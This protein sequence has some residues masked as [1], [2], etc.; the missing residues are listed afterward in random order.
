M[1][2]RTAD[3]VVSAGNDI[4]SAEALVEKLKEKTTVYMELVTQR[5]IQVFDKVPDLKIVDGT[6]KIHQV[7]IS[8]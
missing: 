6:M 7:S 4:V 2:K 1:I 3:G 8:Q 5:D